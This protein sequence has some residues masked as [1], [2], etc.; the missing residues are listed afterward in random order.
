ML[1]DLQGKLD[2]DD[3]KLWIQDIGPDGSRSNLNSLW[4]QST[5]ESPVVSWLQ[6][7]PIEL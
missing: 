5:Y 4:G 2:P 1:D 3:Y 6:W 7:E